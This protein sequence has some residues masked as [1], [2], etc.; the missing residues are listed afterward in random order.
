MVG[1]VLCAHIYVECYLDRHLE[2]CPPLV[3]IKKLKFAQ[4]ILRMDNNSVSVQWILPGLKQLNKL[5][6]D[7][8]HNL[9]VTVGEHDA[10]VF[11]TTPG[12]EMY[13]QMYTLGTPS[14]D[15]TIILEEFAHHAAIVLSATSNPV[16]AAM[17]RTFEELTV[18]R[19]KPLA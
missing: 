18:C 17:T 9:H 10:K 1:R 8:A 19:H 12:F 5:R 14:Q 2:N 3:N 6:N 15:P 16:A 4:K 13:R 7:V 11:L